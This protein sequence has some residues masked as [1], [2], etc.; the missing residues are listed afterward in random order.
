M[1]LDRV[2]RQILSE[3]QRDAR[4]SSQ[5]L[6]NKVGLSLSPCWRRVKELEKV[7]LIK[8]YTVVLDRRKLGLSTCVMA[9]VTLKNHGDGAAADF[10]ARVAQRDEVVEC[11]AIAGECDYL[12]K[13]V[14]SDIDAYNDFTNE[15]LLRMP[16]VGSV[17]TGVALREVKCETALPV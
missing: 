17:R 14:V 15:F 2:Q 3:L 10:E 11:Y 9:Q 8:R 16:V 12:L 13:V 6:A 7:G 1:V 5:E 4:I